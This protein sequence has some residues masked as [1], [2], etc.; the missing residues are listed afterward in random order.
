[1][2]GVPLEK[3]TRSKRSIANEI[4][5]MIQIRNPALVSTDCWNTLYSAFGVDPKSTLRQIAHHIGANERT[6]NEYMTNL[7]VE[8]AS[9]GDYAD[10]TEFIGACWRAVR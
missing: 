8:T 10:A 9:M 1:M 7:A 5:A 2:P 3:G 4:V 6:I